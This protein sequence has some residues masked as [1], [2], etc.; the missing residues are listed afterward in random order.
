MRPSSQND[1][2]P[3]TG[4]A[5]VIVDLQNDFLPG[6]NLAVPDGDEIVPVIN[7]YIALFQ[8]KGLP[9]FATRDWHPQNHC[10]FE[11]QRGIWPVHCVQGT[12]GSQFHSDLRLPDSTT[13][14]SKAVT[15]EKDSYSGFEGT[16]LTE[17]LKAAKVRRLLIGGLATDYCVLF[18]VKDA[19]KNGFLRWSAL[20]LCP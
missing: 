7:R 1:L 10:S 18:T 9:V 13:V 16:D 2:N 14:I 5:L 17:R 20:V 12:A 6:G 4:D 8:S 11:P 19:L 3:K 15:K